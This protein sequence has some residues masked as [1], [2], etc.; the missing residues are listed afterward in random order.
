MK[1]MLTLAL[2]GLLASPGAAWAAPGQVPVASV[3]AGSASNAPTSAVPP[4]RSEKSK[5]TMTALDAIEKTNTAAGTMYETAMQYGPEAARTSREAQAGSNLFRNTGD[6][7]AIVQQTAKVY[8]SA[9]RGDVKGVL[10]ASA[11]AIADRCLDV[12]IEAGC[13]A[14]TGPIV[15]QGCALAAQT[16]RLCAETYFEKSAGEAFVEATNAATQAA[17]NGVNA[18][19]DRARQRHEQGKA[20]Q[21][22]KFNSAQV[23]NDQQAIAI[24]GQQQAA[25][26]SQPDD[27]SVALTAALMNGI[28]AAA[29]PPPTPLAAP[30][31]PPAPL[32]PSPAPANRSAC[33]S[34]HNESAHPGGCHSAPLGLR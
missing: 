3:D 2:A 20:S 28:F 13:M 17:S 34:G 1:R 31:P 5:S 21:Q 11:A 12:A 15:G 18:L 4:P 23:N 7:L 14:A 26:Q 22:A 25:P 16:V 32:A 27:G 24:A 30:A 19:L 8:D 29:A 33:H 9:R 10:D 6:G